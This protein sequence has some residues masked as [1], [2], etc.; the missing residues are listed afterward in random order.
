MK[1]ELSVIIFAY[2]ALVLS[3]QDVIKVNHEDKKPTISDFA[4]AYLSSYVYDGNDESSFNEE[5]QRFKQAWILHTQ[6]TTQKKGEYLFI[7]SKHN[8]L[9]FSHDENHINTNVEMRFW[10][11]SDKKHKLLAISVSR[12]KIPQYTPEQSSDIRFYHYNN[13]TKEMTYCG[14]RP[15][16][17][18]E[19]FFK[20]G[21]HVTYTMSATGKYKG[22]DIV[23]T[24][25]D[26]DG[27]YRSFFF[28]WS[29]REFH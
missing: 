5:I 1:R 29:G 17:I 16:G 13:D 26:E 24:F 3:A 15:P 12:F 25:W 9:C 11:E 21:C 10:N 23:A 6:G 18:N 22:K 7:D 28:K 4:W 8:H 2:F 20:D 19:K 27:D 14:N